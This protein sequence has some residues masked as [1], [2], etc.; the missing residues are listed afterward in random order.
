MS[1]IGRI[2]GH[3]TEPEEVRQAR[4]REGQA[5][6]QARQRRA[7][8]PERRQAEQAR[9]EE[10]FRVLRAAARAGTLRRFVTLGV[11]VADGALWT[12]GLDDYESRD[13]S[14][15]LGPLAGVEAGVTGGTSGVSAGLVAVFGV[16]GAL[17]KRV[18]ADA[19]VVFPDGSTHV[20]SVSGPTA[21]RAAQT[22]AIQLTALARRPR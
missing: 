22:E 12:I 6:E 13:T 5:A 2:R 16:A 18:K 8:A 11:Q 1:L 15:R 7:A 4:E 3:F 21:V 17:A 9:Q 10:A 20:R 19:V 14:V